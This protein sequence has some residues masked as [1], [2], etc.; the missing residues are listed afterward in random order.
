MGQDGFLYFANTLVGDSHPDYIC[1][2]H[3]LGPRTI[4]QKE[5]LDL[6]VAPSA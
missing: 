4:I 1:H 6:R 2:A 5:P 3:Y